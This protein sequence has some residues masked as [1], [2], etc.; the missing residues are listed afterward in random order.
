MRHRLGRDLQPAFRL[1]DRVVVAKRDADAEET[2]R[3]LGLCKLVKAVRDATEKAPDL[4]QPR[5]QGPGVCPDRPGLG[6]LIMLAGLG[7]R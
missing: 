6:R 1:N 7:S 3:A 5:L 4:G 2:D